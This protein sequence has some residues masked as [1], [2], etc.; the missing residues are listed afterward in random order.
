M[1]TTKDAP[2]PELQHRDADRID[3][4]AVRRALGE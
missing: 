4:N 3:W 2:R 1:T